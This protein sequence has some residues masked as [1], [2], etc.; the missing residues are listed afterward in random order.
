MM[1]V[2]INAARGQSFHARNLTFRK[3]HKTDEK[4]YKQFVCVKPNGKF[5]PLVN[6]KLK[7]VRIKN[8]ALINIP[9]TRHHHHHRKEVRQV[10]I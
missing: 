6:K 2:K 5:S 4:A 1:N 3:R 8:I 7:T 9:E 10:R